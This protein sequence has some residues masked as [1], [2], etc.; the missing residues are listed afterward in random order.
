M[1]KHVQKAAALKY[2]QSNQAA[3]VVSASGKGLTAENIINKAKENNIPVLEDPSLVELLAEL[4]IN[5]KIPE[6]LYQAVAEVFA[7]I[8]HTDKNL[9][10]TEKQ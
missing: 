2:D 8:Y 7:F 1:N 10:H 6:E 9:N 5:E 4:N 3:P